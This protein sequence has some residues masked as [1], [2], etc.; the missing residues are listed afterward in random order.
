MQAPAD[1][2]CLAG[3]WAGADR[4]RNMVR[5]GLSSGCDPPVRDRYLNTIPTRAWRLA[6][7]AWFGV[8]LYLT[9]LPFNFGDMSLAEA[10][11]RFQ[12]IRFDGS[13]PRARQQWVSNLLMFVPLGFFWAGWWLHRVRNAW[14]HMAGAVA[15][16]GFCLMVTTT[17]EFLQFWIPNRGPSL[18]DISAN[19]T[20]GVVGA[21]AWLVTRIPVVRQAGRGLL[22]RRHGPDAW[23]ALYLAAYV[24]AS[25]L[26]L[27][28]VL[29]A[30]EFSAR[31]ASAGSGLWVAPDGCWAGGRCLTLRVVE[32]V[33]V[34]PLG[35]WVAW[36]FPGSSPRRLMRAG[37]AGALLGLAVETG[38]FM[39][40]S[41]IAEGASVLTRALGAALGAGIWVARDRIP[42]SW[43][44]GNLRPLL[45]AAMPV[46][47]AAVALVG[48]AGAEGWASAEA[49]RAQFQSMR[50]LP[51]YYH[52]FVA[53]AVA[54]QSVL[55]GMGMYVF[56]GL[57][58]WLWDNRHPSGA[59]PGRAVTAA[60][61]AAVLSS[62]VEAVRLWL[63][64]LRPDTAAPILAALAA[65]GTYLAL[66][67]VLDGWRWR[68]ADP[69]RGSTPAGGGP[70]SG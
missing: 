24:L 52:Y 16:A 6:A 68:G 17:V 26:P 59:M 58:F 57:G 46:Y 40:V 18:T 31:M 9:L 45:V 30:Q 38:Q 12:N 49:A 60:A 64:A 65:S 34:A 8:V 70:H 67:W 15:V 11:A 4:S 62:G 42:W 32:A 13:G 19:A 33:L 10:W 25:L 44:L 53:E 29:S 20:G 1:A 56:V 63:A 7:L 2:T 41:G 22:Q 35:L 61:C 23:M 27:D 5:K 69:E 43:M 21:L 3:E 47:I 50:W 37:A 28:L 14:V 36:R 51:L 55:L 48:F 54:I 39:T 66:W